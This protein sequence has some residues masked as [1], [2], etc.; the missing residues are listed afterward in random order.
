MLATAKYIPKATLTTKVRL[1]TDIYSSTIING[2]LIQLSN[3]RPV[4]NLQRANDQKL[5]ALAVAIELRRA[6][7]LQTISAGMRPL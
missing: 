1:R 3:A 2:M 6:I 7:V 4:R 5:F